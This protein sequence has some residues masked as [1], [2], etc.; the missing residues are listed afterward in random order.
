VR[1]CPSI[2]KYRE[3]ESARRL[4]D[5]WS[6]DHPQTPSLFAAVFFKDLAC[7]FRARAC[8]VPSRTYSYKFDTSHLGPG[9][10][11]FLFW[12]SW[13]SSFLWCARRRSIPARPP[14]LLAASLLQ[15]T[16]STAPVVN[17]QCAR[18][19]P[20]IDR[21]GPFVHGRGTLLPTPPKARTRAGR[22]A[23]CSSSG[24]AV[25]RVSRRRSV[26]R[27][28]GSAHILLD[29][30][31]RLNRMPLLFFSSARGTGRPAGGARRPAGCLSRSGATT[32]RST[33][34]TVVACVLC[35]LPPPAC[36]T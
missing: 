2:Q 36:P 29:L 20:D 1:T 34:R 35:P 3:D 15:I 24:P 5:H 17:E 26:R 31:W 4:L 10:S 23:R 28:I 14:P 6:S 22:P 18:A 12:D 13:S 21:A 16:G 8:Q 27:P 33:G 32:R 19:W 7:H 30:A 11:F 9:F 25:S